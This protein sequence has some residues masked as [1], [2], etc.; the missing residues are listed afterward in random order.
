MNKQPSR[1]S[2]LDK[3]LSP[4]MVDVSA[5]VPTTRTAIASGSITLPDAVAE[6]LVDGD[7]QSPKG[8]VFHTAIIAGTQAAKQTSS[9]IPFC[10]TIPLE[11][12]KIRITSPDPH[13]LHIEASVRATH[14]TGVEMEAL[15]AVSVTALTIY[16]M[17][18]V[19][20]SEISIHNIH[21]V[22]KRG[23][24]KDFDTQS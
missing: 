4:T 11:S 21:L 23:G 9:L 14:K 5:K 13:T 20:S 8:S 2:H 15:T 10:H 24:K 16:D 17:C 22:H 3:N 18:K 7:I 6:H 1:F 19:F 12:C